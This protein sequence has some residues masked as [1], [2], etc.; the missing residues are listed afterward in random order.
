MAK[1]DKEKLKNVAGTV[2]GKGKGF[3]TEFKEFVLRGN[4]MDMAVGVIIGGAFATIVTA[5]TN[6]F[7]NPLINSI[8]G[9]EIGGQILLPWTSG[10]GAQYLLWGD[11]VTSVINFLIMAF[12]LFLMLKFVNGLVALTKKKKE[13]ETESE[14]VI[15]SDETVLLEQILAELKKKK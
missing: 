7:I 10:E 9:A 15:K 5:L 14:V 13:E 2:A 4:V 11:F 3:L 8:G 6:D 1:I 12:I